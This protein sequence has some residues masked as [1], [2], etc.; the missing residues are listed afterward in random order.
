[1]KVPLN[2]L[3]QYVDI[4][5]SIA[6][7]TDKLTAIGHM[8]DKKPEKVEDDTVIDLEVRQ[9][10]S[11]CYSILGIARE[12]AAVTGRELQFQVP[13]SKFQISENKTQLQ[14]SNTD[15]TLCLRFSAARIKLTTQNTQLQTP[16]WM[17]THLEAY[18]MKSISPLVDVTN[19]VM[20]ETGEP[21]H[22]F[23]VR[24][25]QDSH[26]T[27]RRAR[28]GETV[29][30]LGGRDLTLIHDDL[31]I[32]DGEKI[33]SFS[34]L[35][36]AEGTGIAED[37]QECI[38]EAATY[39]QACIRRSSIRHALRTEASTRHE[40]FLDPRLVDVALA[41]ALQLIGEM[42]EYEV[43]ATTESYPTPVTPTT[44]NLRLS[45]VSR[46]GGIN[47]DIDTA[48]QLLTSLGFHT[49]LDSQF[50]TLSC[51]V[52][53]WRTDITQEA[54][55]VEEV[56]RLYGYERIS[57][58]L[59]AFAPP[60]DITSY[61]YRLDDAIRD[62]MR[63]LGYDEIMTEPL[64]AKEAAQPI[65]PDQL[66]KPVILQNALNADKSM[67]RFTME[68]GLQHAYVHH[69]KFD[70]G[71]LKLFELGK[72]YRE[73]TDSKKVPRF[74]EQRMCAFV[75]H[76]QSQAKE[77]LYR[78]A[79]GVV[80]SLCATCAVTYS[81]SVATISLWDEHS[82]YVSLDL[83]THFAADKKIT[84][85]ASNLLYTSIPN[86]QSFD[87]SC[88]LDVRAQIGPLIKSI[89]TFPY[90][91]KVELKG[92]PYIIENQK[93]ILLSITVTNTKQKESVMQ[94]L[95]QHIQ[96]THKVTIR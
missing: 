90:V 62:H 37:T 84:T 10:R 44:L 73:S 89:T 51:V 12:V 83:T 58:V 88:M 41:R 95:V 68:E 42:G 40:K 76:D 66:Y 71:M 56:L 50:S 4:P 96:D 3:K 45:E 87:I 67:L 75:L 9:N 18:G 6:E 43:V 35:I 34:G 46:L 86:I 74:T 31:V 17:K 30:V 20:I 91:E 25:V 80:Q 24:Q 39:N 60:L 79:K 16:P 11:D 59:P 48:N 47:I 85:K 21:M 70:R 92:D 26:L 93:S 8:Q 61:A 32:A 15:P 82:V 78:H 63:L 57:A 65:A 55:L 36:G 53:Y 1:M 2:W 19:Y 14:I 81:D 7:L 28:K 77:V 27:I 72:V 13:S 23:D 38:L 22:A 29:T 64:T 49:T 69:Q 94:T 52:P 5:V 33:L 54:D